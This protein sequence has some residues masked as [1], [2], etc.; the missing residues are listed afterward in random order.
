VQFDNR[1]FYQWIKECNQYDLSQFLPFVVANKTIAYLH[2]NNIDLLTAYPEIELLNN[3]LV[4]SNV[5]VNFEQRTEVINRIANDLHHQQIIKSWVGEQYNVAQNFAEPVLFTIERAA[6]TLFGIQKYGV[7]VNG[8]TI[9]N[10]RYYLWIAKRALDKPTWPGKLDHLVAGG[11]ASGMS[12]QATLEKECQE[13]AGMDSKLA[14]QAV[15]VGLVDYNL[16]VDNKLSRD[17]LFIYDI[18]LPH[19]FKPINTDGEVEEFFLLPIEEVLQIV[20]QTDN[21]KTNCNLVIID[22]AIRHGFIQPDQNLYTQ[23]VKGLRHND[24]AE[25]N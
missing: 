6:A 17:T 15:A 5:I 8:Y 16:Q 7:H 3:Q 11:H 21:F 4:F 1:N 12:I 18:E 23:I 20:N 13:E 19:Y 2:K 10:N 9:K 24:L 14:K 22:F 25:L